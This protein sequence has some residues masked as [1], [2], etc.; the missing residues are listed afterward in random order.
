MY[1]N[2]CCLVLLLPG[3][4]PVY[5]ALLT[6]K[7]KFLHDLFIYSVPGMSTGRELSHHAIYRDVFRCV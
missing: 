6:P 1:L 2:T 5:A 4:P 3:T 7:G